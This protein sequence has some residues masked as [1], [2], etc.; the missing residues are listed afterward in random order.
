MNADKPMQKILVVDDSTE[1][2]E[3]LFSML[4]DEYQVL[5]STSGS[6]AISLAETAQPDIILLDIV[7]PEMDGYEVITALKENEKTKAIP[8]IF[9]TAKTEKSD[10]LKGF[11]LGSVDYIGKPFFEEEIKARLNTHLQNRLLITQLE[12]ANKQLEQIS[13]LDALTGIG[14]RRYFDQFLVQMM[15]VAQREDKPLSLLMIDVDYFKNYND[16]YGHLAGDKCLQQIAS[17]LASMSHRGGDLA[18]RYGGEEFVLVLSDTEHE[19]AK[20]IAN[21]FRLAVDGLQIP[22]AQSDVSANVTVSIG[23]TTLEG[24]QNLTLEEFIKGADIALYQAKE[25]GRNQITSSL[26]SG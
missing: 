3:L 10:L 26:A 20:N 16:L 4:K 21:E 11:E 12:L 6:K 19:S 18:A 24:K 17:T 25:N 5:F 23:Y 2:I 1:N 13:M 15:A 8:V 22:H 9:L 7:M 14:N